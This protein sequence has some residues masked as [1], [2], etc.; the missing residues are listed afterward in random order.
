[1]PLTANGSGEINGQFTIPAQTFAPGAKLV[2]AVGG[3]GSKASAT[4]F[5]SGT[6]TVI[7][8]RNVVTNFWWD[9]LA[10]TFSLPQKAQIGGVSLWLEAKGATAITVQLRTVDVGLPT[11]TIIT[12]AR[13]ATAGLTVGAYNDWIFPWPV[14]LQPNQEY[15]IVALCDDAV[16]SLG[17]AELGKWDLTNEQWVTVQPYQVG[18]L[19]SSSNAS[20][21]TPHQDRDLTFKLLKSSYSTTA[22]RVELG[23]LTVTN[24][25][26]F[27]VMAAAEL[28]DSVTWVDYKV[29]LPAGTKI[30]T[31]AGAGV[32]FQVVSG[33]ISVG[34][35]QHIMLADPSSGT[36]S[37]AAELHGSADF[38]PILFPH[39]QLIWGTIKSQGTYISRAI[40]AGSG[41]RLQ[42]IYDA[43]IPSGASINLSYA[44]HSAGNFSSP[45]WQTSNMTLIKDLPMDGNYREKTYEITGITGDYVRV[46]LELNGGAGARP[47]AQNLRMM[48]M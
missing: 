28:P 20:T 45:S 12:Q 27:L 7:L 24:M 22:R 1:M 47:F 44:I 9:P 42:V 19:L 46:K 23:A 21:W 17:L 37:L 48:V 15:A 38:S 13:R 4:F 11:R 30:R 18:V 16:S 39:P 35:G 40:A 8:N 2:E 33:E 3:A 36:V 32:G 5:G 34:D 41:V 29:T 6:R 26:D 10:Q 14:T 31:G 25:T 43:D